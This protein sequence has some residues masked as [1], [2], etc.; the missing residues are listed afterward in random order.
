M[1][2]EK[3]GSITHHKSDLIVGELITR[4][5]YEPH[6]VEQ[7]EKHINRESVVLDIGANIG[8][9]TLLFAK[10]AKRVFAFEPYIENYKYLLINLYNNKISNVSPFYLGISDKKEV[11]KIQHINN[12]NSGQ[13]I[14]DNNPDSILFKNL[15]NVTED[16]FVQ[17]TTIDALDLGK[18]DFIKID[19]E[20]YEPK[21]LAGAETIIKK[22]K[23]IIALEDW[24]RTTLPTLESWGYNILDVKDPGYVKADFLATP[25]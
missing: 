4:G 5:I 23:P 6:M 25:K 18:I 20:G 21:V 16:I 9:H 19:T 15:V 7:F 2:H 17:C 13:V 8:L 10:L 3:L 24:G 14:L 12:I 11:V 22:Y 1:I